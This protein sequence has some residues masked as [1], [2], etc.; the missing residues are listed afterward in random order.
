MEPTGIEP[1]TSWLQTRESTD[2]SD[3]SKALTPTT[4]LA[5]TSACT[6]EAENVNAL[7]AGQQDKSEELAMSQEG[8]I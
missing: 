4:F 8:V 3:D 1:A 6:S 7:D 2:V 5:C